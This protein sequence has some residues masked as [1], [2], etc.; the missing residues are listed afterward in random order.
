MVED[1]IPAKITRWT[2][3][4]L[5]DR[6]IQVKVNDAYS[7]TIIMSAGTAQGGVTSPDIFNY[8]IKDSVE[9]PCPSNPVIPAL[10]ADNSSAL[11]SGRSVKNISTSMQS[12]L[13]KVD[14][15]TNRWRLVIAPHK[16][17]VILLTH[18]FSHLETDVQIQIKGVK[19]PLKD[20]VN[21]L[22]LHL[23]RKLLFSIHLLGAVN[24]CHDRHN[25]LRC[26]S[27]LQNRRF[28]KIIL[29][30]YKSLM[31]P[32]MSY[33][34]VAFLQ[35]ANDHL[36]G[37]ERIQLAVILTALG[38]PCYTPKWMLLRAADLPPILD[39]LRDH[40]RRRLLSIWESSPVFEA[41]V[42][43]RQ[44]VTFPNRHRSPMEV[45]GPL[46][47]KSRLIPTPMNKQQGEESENKN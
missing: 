45:L 1:A 4:L 19:I 32:I 2:S 37:L 43:D 3:N 31:L 42:I 10:Y 46:P 21:Y 11:V 41:D 15:W 7:D 20:T 23:D 5:M 6:K 9:P 44:Q 40:E 24:K 18:C 33:G 29:G 13:D 8:Y 28:P 17:E 39:Q 26:L 30:L 38:L 36:A 16:S 34:C 47:P 25:L 22:G 12:F 14:R 27:F 35:S